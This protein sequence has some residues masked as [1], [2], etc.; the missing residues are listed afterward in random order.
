MAVAIA[1]GKPGINT[2]LVAS[3]VALSIVLPFVAFPLIWLT[4]S[5]SIMRVRKPNH[6][7]EKPQQASVI[8]EDAPS[9]P[10][11]SVYEGLSV[12]VASLPFAVHLGN[13]HHAAQIQ[14]VDAPEAEAEK[15]EQVH[16][17]VSTG[18]PHE[19]DEF[20]DFS[21]GPLLT[22]AASLIFVVVLAANMYVIIILALGRA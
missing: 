12:G 1:V 11:E 6:Q 17:E 13:R 5:K 8:S 9:S 4:S 20:I 7:R 14:Q 18:A 19:E 10:V 22:A 2:L 3:Q 15:S 16:E 21:N